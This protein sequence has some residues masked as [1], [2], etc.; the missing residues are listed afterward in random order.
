MTWALQGL[1]W[2]SISPFMG[3]DLATVSRSNDEWWN[4]VSIFLWKAALVA[5]GW[6]GGYDS[7]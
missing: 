4:I 5:V 6:Y 7:T 3:G 1:L 2:S